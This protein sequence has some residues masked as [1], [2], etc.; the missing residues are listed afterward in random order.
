M[1]LFIFGLIL[2]IFLQTTL[3]PLNLCLVLFCVRSLVKAQKS[4]LY[5]SLI[6]GVLLGILSSVNIGFYP[7]IF[8]LSIKSIEVF[9]ASY[10]YNNIIFFL[11][12]LFIIYLIISLLSGLILGLSFSFMQVIFETLISV[13]FYFLIKFWEER[14][15][16][17]PQIKLKLKT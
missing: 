17:R 4:T 11:P 1:K 10:L 9:K 13:P 5:I 15:I 2:A 3:L 6:F 14:F 12:I 7:L 16:V 8:L